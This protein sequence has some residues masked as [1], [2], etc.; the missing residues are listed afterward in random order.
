MYPLL[1]GVWKKLKKKSSREKFQL[2]P[3]PAWIL[4]CDLIWRSW[5]KR[6]H[7]S[8][9]VR[10][11]FI[12]S[13]AGRDRSIIKKMNTFLISF[14]W[15]GFL[16]LV[17][18]FV[19]FCQHVNVSLLLTLLSPVAIGSSSGGWLI[20]GRTFY[21]RCETAFQ[22]VRPRRRRFRTRFAAAP[23][24]TVFIF[25]PFLAREAPRQRWPTGTKRREGQS[26]TAERR[27]EVHVDYQP[28]GRIVTDRMFH[29]QTQSSSRF[30]SLGLGHKQKSTRLKIDE[31]QQNPRQSQR[32]IPAQANYKTNL[33]PQLPSTVGVADFARSWN[34]SLHFRSMGRKLLS[35]SLSL[36]L[37][38][39]LCVS[40][41]L[42]SV[43]W[44]DGPDVNKALIFTC[45]VLLGLF[46]RLP[47][48]FQG[49][50]DSNYSQPSSDL[51]LDDERE[52]LRRE[53]ER[54]ALAQLEKARV[55]FLGSLIH[56]SWAR[57]P[58]FFSLQFNPI[59]F[60]FPRLTIGQ[61]LVLI[62]WRR[63]ESMQLNLN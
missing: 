51:S 24:R 10:P 9:I 44:E 58:F 59:W 5:P 38:I 52:A 53:T 30:D 31:V 54:L 4:R 41:L 56:F 25:S 45:R 55:S 34:D 6:W 43:F 35:L 20:D 46:V 32:V 36:S 27:V 7:G 15:I 3:V 13:Y 39:S 12:E 21:R 29:R 49:S 26:Q 16:L 8:R 11:T 18:V 23:S 22:C 60:F 62:S 57:L 37:S 47:F 17:I 1:T 61:Y 2:D 40:C 33:L 28:K 63:P 50:A 19:G 42:L 14:P 48:H